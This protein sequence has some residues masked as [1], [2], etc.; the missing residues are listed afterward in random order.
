MSQIKRGRHREGKQTTQ[1]HIA[2]E[3]WSQDWHP[4]VWSPIPFLTATGLALSSVWGVLSAQN[5]FSD[6]DDTPSHN[7]GVDGGLD[8]PLAG[9]ASAEG[10]KGG[11]ADL[12][13][14]PFAGKQ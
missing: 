5:N 3:W 4:A 13:K 7:I 11:R 2:S 9:H 10:P 14:T 12:V 1:D 6:E 8:M